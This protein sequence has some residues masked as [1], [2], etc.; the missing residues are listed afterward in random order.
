MAPVRNKTTTYDIPDRIKCIF[1]AA[2]IRCPAANGYDE[3]ERFLN[4]AWTVRR[5]S[6]SALRYSTRRSYVSY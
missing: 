6:L 3:M 4:L 5:L 2:E 1:S